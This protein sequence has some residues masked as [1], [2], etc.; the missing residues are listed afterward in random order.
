MV[1]PSVDE[2]TKNRYELFRT[3]WKKCYDRI[4]TEFEQ[5]EDALRWTDQLMIYQPSQ[6]RWWCGCASYRR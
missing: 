4:R 6:E 5:D 1:W 2:L 3:S